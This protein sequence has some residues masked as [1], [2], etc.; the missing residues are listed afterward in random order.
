MQRFRSKGNSGVPYL[1]NK[2]LNSLSAVQDTYSSIKDLFER[3]RVVFTIGTSL[4]SVATAWGGYCLRHLYE[5]KVNQRLESIEN[6]MKN[7]YHIEHAEF[8]KLVDPGN[9]NIATCIATAGTT[10]VV[11]Y[12]FGW[13]GGRWYANRKFREEQMKLLG[14][15]KPKRWQLL[16][17]VTTEDGF[18]LGIQRVTKGQSGGAPGSR[19]PVLLQH[20]LLMDGIT[21]LLLPPEQSLAFLLADNGFDVW[22]ANTRGTKYSLGHTSLSPN[23]AA[24]WG[25]SWDE[26]VSYDLPATFEYVNG[27]TGQKLHYVGHSL[28]TL[29]ALAAF[30]KSQQLNMLRSAA[31]LS[32][33][34]YVGQITSP[35]ATNAADNFIAEALYWLGLHEFDPRGETV[36]KF[37]KD[38]CKKKNIDCTN[39][40]NSFTGRN[41]CLN[42]SIVDIFLDHE[43]QSTA[44][45]N[46]IHI[47][48]MIRTGT[49]AMYDYNDEDENKKHYGQPTPPLYNM[50]SI[51]NNVPLF[52]SYGGADA[53]SDVKDVQLLINSLKDH[54]QDKLVIQFRDDYAHADFVM[55]QNAAQEVYVPLI[56]FFKLQ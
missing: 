16:G 11:G 5:S 47:S 35:L 51:P 32:P 33:I 56:D 21:W 9:S 45:K 12:G 4:A 37:L 10:F 27:Q 36:V 23:D 24:Y 38:I 54:D 42:S 30:S 22:I 20:G 15:I 18:I 31:L 3:H 13:R 53:L 55:A 2:A 40:L 17:R 7:N 39:L 29:I 50:A 46:M 14:H 49:I 19:P 34:A 44:T 6:A 52:L 25:W 41:C 48:Q 1:K 8:K 26:L 28:G 43:P